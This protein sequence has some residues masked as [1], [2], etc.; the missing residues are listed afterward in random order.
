MKRIL[1]FLMITHFA[2][3]QSAEEIIRQSEDLLKGTSSQGSFRMTVTTPSFTRTI[4]MDSWWVGNEKALIVITSPKR[5]A[6][7]KTLKVDNE[8]WM[9][10]RN[11]ETTIKVPPS[12][13]L[14]SW[15]GSDFTNDDLVRE[16]SLLRDYFISMAGEETLDGEPCWNVSLTPRP[17]AP[18]VWGKIQY[19]VR[20]KDFLPAQVTYFDEKGNLMR[21]M[22]FSNVRQFGKKKLPATW[23]MINNQKPGHTTEMVYLNI[24]FDIPISDRIFSFREAAN[25]ESPR[26]NRMAEHL[27]E[28]AADDYHHSCRHVCRDAVGR[29][30]RDPTRHIR[31]EYSQRYRGVLRTCSD[32]T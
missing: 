29:N 3:S 23:T 26:Q 19:F 28:R 5:D 7:N 1:P 25:R 16:S 2:F 4:E 27:E 24:Q 9:Y 22:L 6:G 13:M 12:M 18:V 20:K 21:T 14:Q 15:N 11:T 10:L 17:T 31:T 8:L 30:A 32:S